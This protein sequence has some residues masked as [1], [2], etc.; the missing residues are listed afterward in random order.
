MDEG[1]GTL[2]KDTSG[3]NNNFTILGTG[4]SKASWFIGL[5]DK[6]YYQEIRYAIKGLVKNYAIKNGTKSFVIK[7]TV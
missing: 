5:R 6:L 1:I 7:P 2:V 4:L 3:N